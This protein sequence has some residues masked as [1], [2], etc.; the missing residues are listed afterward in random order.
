MIWL[1]PWNFCSTWKN[2]FLTKILSRTVF[3]SER[4]CLLFCK[5]STIS[6]PTLAPNLF[7]LSR[8]RV[9]VCISRVLNV[10]DYSGL[11]WKCQPTPH[12][13]H[14]PHYNYRTRA[15]RLFPSR[16]SAESQK[17]DA[18]WLERINILIPTHRYERGGVGFLDYATALAHTHTHI[19]KCTSAAVECSCNCEWCVHHASNSGMLLIP[20]LSQL[21][22]SKSI[23]FALGIFLAAVAHH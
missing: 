15:L 22:K 1:K 12:H 13:A 11:L 8:I 2:Y 23:S 19:N 7:W 18:L 9:D 4:L 16:R 20:R 3:G 17:T 14:Q 21:E 10:C 5:T 6:P